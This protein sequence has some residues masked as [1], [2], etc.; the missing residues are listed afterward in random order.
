MSK[1]LLL[2]KIEKKRE[3]LIRIA[4]EQGLNSNLA[5]EYSQ[6]LDRLLNEYN[7]LF[8]KSSSKNKSYLTPQT[9]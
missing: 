3:D 8:L 6:E 5:I 9:V 2:D 7:R 1:Q 4:C